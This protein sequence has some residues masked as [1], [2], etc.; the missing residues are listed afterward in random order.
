MFMIL[1]FGAF[2]VFCAVVGFMTI[3]KRV[4]NFIKDH[5]V[6]EGGTKTE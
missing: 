1:M 2:C 5:V 3:A 4:M 6:I